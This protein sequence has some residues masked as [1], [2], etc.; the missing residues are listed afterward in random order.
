[1]IRERWNVRD[2]LKDKASPFAKSLHA[3]TPTHLKV[4]KLMGSHH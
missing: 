4:A 1:M 3:G 2:K